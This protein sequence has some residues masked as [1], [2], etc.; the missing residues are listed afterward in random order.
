MSLSHELSHY[1]KYHKKDQKDIA[2]VYVWMKL[3]LYWAQDCA[4]VEIIDW[5]SLLQFDNWWK[6]C[7]WCNWIHKS[8]VIDE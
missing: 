6:I 1:M 4:V 5:L 7:Y 2:K 8:W 3:K